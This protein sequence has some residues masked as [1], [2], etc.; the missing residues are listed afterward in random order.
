MCQPVEGVLLALS[1]FV[2][3]CLPWTD[4][5]LASLVSRGRFRDRCVTLQT[6]RTDFVTGADFCDRRNTFARSGT[7]IMADF[8]T[9]AALWQPQNLRPVRCRFRGRRSTFARS[10]AD[11][12]TGAALAQGQAQIPWQAHPLLQGQVQISWQAQRFALS[13]R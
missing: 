4:S 1:P 2:S 5:F 3:P 13:A 11:F 6:S 10:G 8:V 12:M 9:S 7:D